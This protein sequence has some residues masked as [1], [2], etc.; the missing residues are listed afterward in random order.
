MVMVVVGDLV[1]ISA[2]TRIGR[3]IR[4][5]CMVKTVG[6]SEGR[7]ILSTSDTLSYMLV[8]PLTLLNGKRNK[9]RRIS[10]QAGTLFLVR[11]LVDLSGW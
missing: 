2:R 5:V 7:A 4:S 10:I 3:Q 8:T 1:S 6:S 9:F 11:H